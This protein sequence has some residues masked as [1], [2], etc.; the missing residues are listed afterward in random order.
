[1]PGTVLYELDGHVAT[2]T[3]NRP[4]ALNAI[5]GELREDLNAAWLRFRFRI[6]EECWQS[7]TW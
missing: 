7:T 6:P 2:I 3:Y 1:M 4:D 5:N